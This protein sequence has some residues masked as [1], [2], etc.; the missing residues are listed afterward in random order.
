MKFN[1]Y[2]LVTFLMI[3]YLPINISFKVNAQ[4]IPDDTLGTESSTINSLDELRDAI[5]GGIIRGENLFHSFQE[6][7]VG[8][9]ASVNFANPEGIA[10]IFSRVTGENISEIFGT[11]GV[12]GAANLFLINPNGIIFGENS[13]VNVNGSFLVTTAEEI[14]FGNGDRFSA[15]NPNLPTLKISLPIGLGMGS[16]PGDIEVKGTG[17]NFDKAPISIIPIS[18]FNLKPNQNLSLIGGN[19]TFNGAII[20]IESGNIEIG[21]VNSGNVQIIPNSQAPKF[22]YEDISDFQN[23]SFNSGS[24]VGTQNGGDVFVKGN[25][26][27]VNELSNFGSLNLDGAVGGDVFV[28]SNRLIVTNLGIVSSSNLGSGIGGNVFIESNRLD[29]LN[30]ANLGS[31]NL[32]SGVGGDVFIESSLINIDGVYSSGFPFSTISA[33]TVGLGNAGNMLLNTSSLFVQNGAELSSSTLGTGSAGAVNINAS[34]SIKIEGVSSVDQKPSQIIAGG[35]NVDLT[36]FI[37]FDSDQSLGIAGNIVIN[38]PLLQVFDG[39]ALTTRNSGANNAGNL[40]INANSLSLDNAGQISAATALGQGG[41]IE[42]NTER[43]SLVGNSQIS[44]TAG[45]VGDGGNVTIDTGTL[46]GT[47]NSDIIANALFGN[48][49]NIDIESDVILGIRQSDRLT[50]QSDITAD[51]ELGID[52]TININS[53]ETSADDEVVLAPIRQEETP[54][55][56]VRNICSEGKFDRDNRLTITPFSSRDTTYRNLDYSDKYAIEVQQILQDGKSKKN[57]LQPFDSS[58]SW[59]PGEPIIEPDAVAIASDGTLMLVATNQPQT[60]TSSGL[61][62]VEKND[63][64]DVGVLSP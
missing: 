18:Q 4:I 40:K 48:G 32:G 59:Q 51:S 41:N 63:K 39:A 9:G 27:T 53:P 1:I 57:I 25:N 21:S 28:E 13:V 61:C 38:T 60:I 3:L 16:N 24:L 14:D 47:G 54:V 44:A 22:K 36:G 43:L 31:V 17:N 5:E 29:I 10:N 8:E 37:P 15:V 35:N 64:I 34:E 56:I 23:I 58:S 46:V 12:D 42:L 55:E 26:I 11:L 49:G 50:P 19:V 30:G 45:G 52:G 2:R 20:T 6:F 33:S 7:N 62:Q